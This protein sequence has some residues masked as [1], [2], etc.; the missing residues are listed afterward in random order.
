MKRILVTGASGFVGKE[1]C[2]YLSQAGFDVTGLTRTQ[3]INLPNV[4]LV[5]SSLDVIPATSRVL[6]N[7]DCVIHL[8]GRAHQLNDRAI[9]PLDEFRAV[10]R[11]LTI[12]FAR[13]CIAAGIKR[14]VFISSIGVNGSET[15]A[16]PFTED[17]VC[18][19]T[20]D[21]ALSKYE[22]EIELCKLFENSASEL[23][24]VRPPLVYAADAPGNFNRLL[25][26]VSLGVPLPFGCVRNQRSMISLRNLVSFISL[27][28]T[29]PRAAN[30]TFLIADTEPLSLPEILKSLSE[31]MS[32][33][34]FLLPVPAALLTTA[35][36][37]FGKSAIIKQLCGS[38]VVDSSKS[39]IL[40]GWQPI[41]TSRQGLTRTGRSYSNKSEV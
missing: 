2:A 9:S 33:R 30:E 22:A 31:G 38:L 25:K 36:T 15:F 28:A 40:L 20:A 14:F 21:Y 11:D 37:V 1:L 27:A 24:I 35:A 8:A 10:N 4:H 3:N 18:T 32:R 13:S 7:S 34:S 19:P 17:S 39:R 29:H 6:M 23:V 16:A 41:E 5:E 12:T 26:L